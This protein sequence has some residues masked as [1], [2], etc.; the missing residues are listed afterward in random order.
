MSLLL[1]TMIHFRDIMEHMVETSNADTGISADN[2][3]WQSL[4]RFEWIPSI[5]AGE[6][7]L[8]QANIT[9]EYG[10]EFVDCSTRLVVTPTTQRCWLAINTALSLQT[11]CLC[12]GPTGSGKSEMCLDLARLM[13]KHT[14]VFSCNEQLGDK[15][16]LRL[17]YGVLHCSSWFILDEM[18]K[19]TTETLSILT[20]ESQRV[21]AA[22]LA[23]Q[24]TVR[25]MGQEIMMQAHLI[26][27]T[28]TLDYD[29]RNSLP[30]SIRSCFRPLSLIRPDA[31]HISEVLLLSNGFANSHILSRKLIK[32][33]SLCNDQLQQK[34]KYNFTNMFKM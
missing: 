12:F 10:F 23:N 24:D 6:V 11:S 4:L 20:V 34:I 1:V 22:R 8:R 18:N 21:Q 19:L 9:L 25:V 33:F 7:Y 26:Y 14:V 2:F 31:T 17:L 29:I 3:I 13:G 16:L 28:L 15:V 32:L 27:A 5:N 30:D